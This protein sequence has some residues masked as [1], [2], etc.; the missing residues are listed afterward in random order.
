MQCPTGYIPTLTNY[1]LKPTIIDELVKIPKLRSM[2]SWYR[3]A[4]SRNPSLT[5]PSLCSDSVGRCVTPQRFLG[6]PL[7]TECLLKKLHPLRVPPLRRRE[8]SRA[9]VLLIGSIEAVMEFARRLL[10]V[11]P[12]VLDGSRRAGATSLWLS[13]AFDAVAAAVVGR[14]VDHCEW[15]VVAGH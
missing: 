2:L 9:V 6:F 7:G 12:C 13:L 4:H 15:V 5:P 8:P 10:D 3:R 14:S 11:L 1:S